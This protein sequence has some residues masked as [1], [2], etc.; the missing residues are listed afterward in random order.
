MVGS[1]TYPDLSFSV[2]AEPVKN[3]LKAQFNPSK[4][5]V[6]QLSNHHPL[7]Y[8]NKDKLTDG[9]HHHQVV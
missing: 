6:A 9:R 5:T 1:I 2:L 3:R 4:S 7:H 8:L